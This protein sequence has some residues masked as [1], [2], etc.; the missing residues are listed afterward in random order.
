MP[1]VD[2]FIFRGHPFLWSCPV[3]FPYGTWLVID[4]LKV[5]VV[6]TL[7]VMVVDSLHVLFLIMPSVP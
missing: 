3:L 4:T 2:G 5:M 1:A 6:D 7:K